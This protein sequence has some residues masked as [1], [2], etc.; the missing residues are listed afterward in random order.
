MTRS[1]GV[2]AS[3][4]KAAGAEDA[5]KN[6]MLAKNETPA[7]NTAVRRGLQRSGEQNS[8]SCPI[9]RENYDPS[10]Q[11]AAELLLEVGKRGSGKGIANEGPGCA[12][13]PNR[14]YEA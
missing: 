13:D 10:Q 11:P 6:R 2:A 5:A 8:E 14:I 12:P 7:E 4:V 1:I 9:D 3:R